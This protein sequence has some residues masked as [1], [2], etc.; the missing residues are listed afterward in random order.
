[1]RERREASGR[2]DRRKPVSTGKRIRLTD[3]DRRW[4]RLLAD[5]GPLPT[6]FLLEFAKGLGVSE[7]RARERLTDLFN[8]EE[9]AHGG[10][11]L[12]RPPQQFHT[13]DS[14]YNQL[15]YDLSEAGKAALKET[16]DLPPSPSLSG[17]WL[18]R[19]MTSAITASIRLA[20]ERR[21][22]LTY[23]PEQAILR[24]ANATI[25][26]SLEWPEANGRALQ[27][28]TL[29]PD[30][31]FGLEYHT[32]KGSRFRFFALEADRATEPLTSSNFNRKSAVKQFGLYRAYIETGVYR[33]HLRLTSPMIV[34]NVSSDPKR[35]DR[36]LA[37]AEAKLGGVNY[38][39]F[40][41]WEAFA[42]PFR[43]PEPN[44]DLLEGNWQRAGFSSLHLDHP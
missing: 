17:P 34:L 22:D 21:A 43:P 38:Q 8:E 23:I 26:V 16:D 19:F 20:A 6:S 40:Q 14:R 12:T 11:Y 31:I 7:K 37:L 10:A 39:L 33:Q 29:R 27:K 35:T 13:L 15:V 44:L 3:R 25:D 28:V 41:S 4:L 9:T 24:R 1:M 18:H 42:P 30:A 32:K 2:R 5:H 36:L